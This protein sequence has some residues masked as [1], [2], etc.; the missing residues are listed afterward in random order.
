M[1]T[2]NQKKE[3]AKALYLKGI[4]T[5][6]ILELTGVC[7]QTLSRWVNKEGW[8]EL[9]SAYGMTREEL[10]KKLMAVASKAIDNPEEY[11]KNKKLADDLVKIMSA[12]EKLDKTTNVVHYVEAFIGFENWLLEH[13]SDYPDLPENI[14]HKL[15][16][17]FDAYVTPLLT[18]K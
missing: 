1:A 16:D 3:T 2:D 15:H 5:E 12:I 14:V 6:K 18:N 4:D 8:K 9:R 13:L 17:A 11:Q 7:R 10:K